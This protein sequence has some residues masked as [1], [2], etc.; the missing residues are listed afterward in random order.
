MPRSSAAGHFTFDAVNREIKKIFD[1][2]FKNPIEISLQLGPDG[3]LYGLAEEAIF[4]IDPKNG[5]VSLLARPPAPITAG[6]AILGRKIYFGSGA[7][8]YEFG[9]PLEPAPLKLAE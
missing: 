1:L 6:M 7:N 3:R 5:Q 4:A 9:I 8:L 2:G